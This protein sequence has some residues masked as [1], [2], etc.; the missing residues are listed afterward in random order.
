MTA[1]LFDTVPTS[2]PAVPP[3]WQYAE[4]LLASLFPDVGSGRPGT[5]RFFWF[6][7]KRPGSHLGK[8]RETTSSATLIEKVAGGVEVSIERI[9]PL[10]RKSWIASSQKYEQRKTVFSQPGNASGLA[11]DPDMNVRLLRQRL[12]EL[13]RSRARLTA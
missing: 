2:V 8:W 7:G 4:H 11:D 3:E 5:Y 12:Q 6:E 10:G 13:Q 1:T 9:E